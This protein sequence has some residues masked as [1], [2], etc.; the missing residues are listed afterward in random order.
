MLRK[1]GYEE[2]QLCNYVMDGEFRIRTPDYII[3]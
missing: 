3:T 1:K 2:F